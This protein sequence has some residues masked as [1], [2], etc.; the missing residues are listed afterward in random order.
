MTAGSSWKF[1]PISGIT[2]LTLVSVSLVLFIVLGLK[3]ATPVSE[4]YQALQGRKSMGERLENSYQPVFRR[5]Q[6]PRTHN[7]QG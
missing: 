7:L 2:F 6:I 5:L 1:P 3:K 4:E